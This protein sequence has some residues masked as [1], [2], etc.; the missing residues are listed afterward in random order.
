MTSARASQRVTTTEMGFC[1]FMLRLGQDRCR[2]GAVRRAMNKPT[3]ETYDLARLAPMEDLSLAARGPTQE[4]AWLGVLLETDID[5]SSR[6]PEVKG[7]SAQSL[8]FCS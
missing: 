7:L 8:H 3:L 6:R 5:L 4:D 1:R 2:G